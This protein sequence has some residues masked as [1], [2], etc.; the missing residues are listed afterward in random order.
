V[1]IPVF[2]ETKLEGAKGWIVEKG[3]WRESSDAWT[4]NRCEK[5]MV[6]LGR[7]ERKK[8]TLFVAQEE[9]STEGAW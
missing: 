8:K 2:R 4:E 9:E 5:E 3:T 1:Y 7:D 6:D